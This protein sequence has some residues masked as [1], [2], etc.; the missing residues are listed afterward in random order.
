MGTDTERFVR[1]IRAAYIERIDAM[2][3]SLIQRLDRLAEQLL[4]KLDVHTSDTDQSLARIHHTDALLSEKILMIE[5]MIAALQR[6]LT[7]H[8]RKPLL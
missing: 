2:E 5:H 8:K 3:R 1:T 7:D 6:E 4:H